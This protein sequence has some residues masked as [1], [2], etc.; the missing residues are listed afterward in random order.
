MTPREIEDGDGVRWACVQ[1]Y[2]ALGDRDAADSA[3]RVEGTDRYRVV[4][5]PSG[6]SQSV[7]LELPAGWEEELSDEAMLN[8]IRKRAS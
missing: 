2:A 4:C 3:A 6:G 8:E 7:E 1:A 5:T